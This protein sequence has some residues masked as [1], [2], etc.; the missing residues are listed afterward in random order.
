MD[1][2][3]R[4]VGREREQER[5][6]RCGGGLEEEEEEG[7]L[8]RGARVVEAAARRRARRADGAA[9]RELRKSGGARKNGAG[10]RSDLHIG[11]RSC[12]R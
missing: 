4:R 1:F 11:K 9:E 7:A 8:E 6:G 12:I 2:I 3:R 5:D 10:K